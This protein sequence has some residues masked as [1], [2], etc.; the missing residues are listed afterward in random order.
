MP[1]FM[2]EQPSLTDSEVIDLARLA[3]KLEVA[4]GAPADVECAIAYGE[5]YLLQCRPITTLS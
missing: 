3:V 4:T 5:P 1:R 2:R